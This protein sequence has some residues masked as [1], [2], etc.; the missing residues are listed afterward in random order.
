MV[1][2]DLIRSD[3]VQRLMTCSA[4]VILL[5]PEFQILTLGETVIP[6]HHPEPRSFNSLFTHS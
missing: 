4:E 6:Q 1:D 2:V 3:E 5:P